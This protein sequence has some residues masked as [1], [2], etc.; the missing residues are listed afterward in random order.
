MDNIYT[1]I[2][3]GYYDVKLS[4]EATGYTEEL[5]RLAREFRA[6]AIAYAGLQSHRKADAAY[7]LAYNE[8]HGSDDLVDRLELLCDIA[9]LMK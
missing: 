9:D 3:N 8:R 1:R 4:R 5:N 7:D 2:E 6:D